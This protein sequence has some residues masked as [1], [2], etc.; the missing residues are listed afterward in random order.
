MLLGVRAKA[1]AQKVV[2]ALP[3]RRIED[4]RSN[5]RLHLIA[6]ERTRQPALERNV[7]LPKGEFELAASRQR[8]PGGA[9]GLWW[10]DKRGP[11]TAASAASATRTSGRC[12]IPARR[13]PSCT[14]RRGEVGVEGLVSEAQCSGIDALRGA[15]APRPAFTPGARFAWLLRDALLRPAIRLC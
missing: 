11:S 3:H 2:I 8:R 13:P 12:V 10:T 5:Y 1:V 9:W 7:N 14:G 4:A 15:S 6:A